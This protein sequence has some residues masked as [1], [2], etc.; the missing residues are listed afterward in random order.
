MKDKFFVYRKKFKLLCVKLVH[1]N[2][3]LVL[4]TQVAYKLGKYQK[5]RKS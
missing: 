3:V 4:V 5:K 2:F 1:G